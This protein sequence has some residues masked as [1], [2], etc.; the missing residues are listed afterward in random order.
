[1]SSREEEL[2]RERLAKLQRL[3]DRGI[4][5]YPPRFGRTHTSTAAVA[6]FEAFEAS[7]ADADKSPSVSVAGRVTAMRKMGKAAFLDLQD[8]EGRIQVFARADNL[9]PADFETLKDDVDLGDILGASGPLIRTRAGEISVQATSLTMLA[10]SLQTPPEKFHG[11][12]DVEQRYR[13]RY[14]DLMANEETRDLF[15]LRSRVIS[16][17]RRFLD[18]RG[19]I[20]VET[21]I[22][23][24]QSGGAAARPFS[25]HH[26]TLDRD[27]YL[28][29][30]T[31]LHLKR[32][33]VG[34]FDK[35][36]EIGRIF[37]NE[38][39]S[40]KHSPEY[41]MLESYEAYADYND[42]MRMVEDMVAAIAQETLGTTRVRFG[43]YD[44]ELAPPWKRLPLRDALIEHADLD[45]DN[46]RDVETLK[47]RMLEMGLEPEPGA[48]WG[49]L[50]DQVQSEFVEPKLVQPTFLLDYPIE[51]SPLAKQ[52]PDDPR[53]VERFEA[54]VVGFEFGNAYSELNDPLEQ[55]QRFLEQ[56][57][58]R[59]A[60]D[61][62]TESIDEDYIHALEHGMPPTGGLGIGIDRL[63]MLLADRHNIREV[64]LFPTL[65]EKQP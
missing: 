7:G 53:Y 63:I 54:F 27:L 13:Q 45:I 62:E 18:A 20:E 41:T 5:P 29:I 4:D 38:G 14:R 46:Y 30:A 48:G 50:I 8:G 16:A 59:E 17:M 35:V 49:K 58:L 61:E 9:D 2:Y 36:Y 21:P 37:R 24:D 55:R 39:L 15:R 47:T 19:F 52:K 1:M 6:A 40:W 43:E 57:R 64:I 11:L 60:G 51:L 10:K 22:L 42:V 12:T 31:E 26:N 28:R 65:R 34:G 25:T 56:A 23:T 3:R 44:I 32:L 33:T